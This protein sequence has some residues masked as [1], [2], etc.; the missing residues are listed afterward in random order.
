MKKHILLTVLS[1][2]LAVSC[3]HKP[4][5]AAQPSPSAAAN[6]LADQAVVESP[7][8]DAL[9]VTDVQA[10]REGDR[11]VS[12][13]F[14]APLAAAQDL[15]GLVES[16][17]FRVKCSIK[18][19]QLLVYPTQNADGNFRLTLHEGI[20]AEN[21][22]KT[23]QTFIYDLSFGQSL[24]QV[25]LV[26]DGVIA[27]TGE[28]AWFPFRAVGLNAVDIRII[29]VFP[30]NM[31]YFLQE[32][33]LDE[34]SSWTLNRVGRS[35]CR[36]KIDLRSRNAGDLS[37]WNSFKIDLSKFIDFKP[38]T[39][40]S[41]EIGFRK[42][43]TVSYASDAFQ[44]DASLSRRE[45]RQAAVNHDG[46]R[47]LLPIEEEE[48][49]P[50]YD[51]HDAYFTYCYNWRSSDNP[52][53]AAYYNP[54][55]RFPRR[56]VLC[57]DLGIIVKS[58]AVEGTHVFV[59]G[60]TSA[61]PEAG[62]DVEL[63][64][65][66]MQVVGQGKTDR[67]GVFSCSTARPVNTVFV[68]KGEQAGF[69]RLSNGSLIPSAAFD[70]SGRQVSKG[71]KGFLYA[72]RGVWRPGDSIFLNFILEDR[73]GLLPEGYP[74]HL[75][76][77]NAQGQ[78]VRRM[79]QKV[80][81]GTIYPF[82]LT[83]SPD[84]PTGNWLAVVKAGNLEFRKNLQVESVKPNRLKIHLT[85]PD[86][87]FSAGQTYQMALEAKWLT[88]ATA[89]HLPATVDVAYKP[90]TP[91]FAKFRRY[92][93]DAPTS[94]WYN[95]AE[96]AF[97]GKLSDNGTV[98]FPFAFQSESF[99]PGML[100]AE[101][102]TRVT[103]GEGGFSVNYQSQTI[104][105]YKHYAGIRL[106]WDQPQWN[107]L[108][109]DKNH[110]VAI[111]TVDEL[112][113]PAQVK[114]IEVKL[115]DLEYKWWY[116]GK[117]EHLGSYVGETYHKPV[118]S[119][120]T[121]TSTNGLGEVVLPKDSKR[122]GS[123]LLTVALPDGHTAGQ[124]VWFGGSWGSRPQGDAQVLT[125]LS[126]KGKYNVGEEVKVSFPVSG[127]SRALV[128]VES[129]RGI[130]SR[131]RIIP[132]AATCEY[133]FK[134]TP[135]MAPNVYVSV[136]LLQ[137]HAQTANDLPIRMFGVIPVE[138]ED[139]DTRLQPVLKAPADVRPEK[140]FNLTVAEAG[141]RP[142]DYTIAIVDEG[143][144]D[145]TRFATPDP[146]QHFYAREA[147]SIKTY[148]LYHQVLGAF[149]T[150][151]E[152][153][154]TIGGSDGRIDASKKR[155]DRFPPIVKVLG[156]FHLEKGK[157]GRH[158]VTLEPYTGSVRAMVVAAGDG[159]YGQTQQDISVTEP[160]MVQ[161]GLP[162]TLAPDERL[163]VAVN[164]FS[165]RDGLG[166]VRL[167]FETDGA[168]Q[169]AQS[170]DTVIEVTEAGEYTVPVW[171]KTL[172][173]NL[174]EGM[175]H[176]RVSA[177][178]GSLK[179]KGET[180]IAVRHRNATTVRTRF[181]TLAEG[182]SWSETL[183]AS[184]PEAKATLEVSSMPAMNLSHRLTY[185]LDYPMA[186]TEQTVSGAFPLLYLP[187]LVECSET[188]LA[189]MR[190]RV[191]QAIARLQR[192]QTPSHGFAVWPGGTKA[193]EWTSCY[194]T[195]FLSQASKS[196]YELP[197]YL[198][199]ESL[200]Y[201]KQQASVYRA[202]DDEEDNFVQAYRLWVLAEAGQAQMGCMNR[203]RAN[204]RLNNQGRYLLAHAYLL[205]GQSAAADAL[206]D[207]R[208]TK[209]DA[210]AEESFGTDLRD[211]SLIL[212]YLTASGATAEAS[213]LALDLAAELSS[214]DWL[215]TQSTAA[216]LVALQCFAVGTNAASSVECTLSCN[217]GRAC[218]IGGNLTLLRQ[219]IP[220]EHASASF[221]VTHT[222]QGT[223]FALLSQEERPVGP[224]SESLSQGLQLKCVYRDRKG[225][226]VQ[227]SRLRQ[228]TDFTAEI[229]VT[230]PTPLPVSHL[231]L[232]LAVPSG[233]ELLRTSADDPDESYDDRDIRD[234]RVCT[235]FRLGAGETRTF[236]LPLRSAWAGEFVLP[237]VT[238]EAMYDR[239][240]H[241]AQTGGMMV[242]VTE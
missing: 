176:L 121:R 58:D 130:L 40:Y 184:G 207:V 237:P 86:T 153:M 212:Q 85:S 147:L 73:E 137:P 90:F 149:G 92:R 143:L 65:Y 148:D 154:F 117:E 238:C 14:S 222:G 165:Q 185:L 126:D 36:R 89:A 163:R 114:N 69:L 188:E 88:G 186:C 198:L 146:W 82:H 129:S 3:Q 240:R 29:E 94:A 139:P 21:G 56:N 81:R 44:A 7:V 98:R 194:A 232:T 123:F 192:H 179:A 46:D 144:L 174:P 132:T 200:S 62:A 223:L 8:A 134:A 156:P 97:E 16:D 32:N 53:H 119:V 104:S 30:D 195:L 213:A 35:V 210:P 235:C 57:S 55:S 127:E 193:H 13:T 49:H 168:L 51:Y 112:G 71:V 59:N 172:S 197:A 72:D 159:R 228:G 78:M 47:F 206:V 74:L 96:T 20:A 173:G 99:V 110:V 227:A 231:M 241:Y 160:L 140:P 93:F 23:A 239:A 145:L 214:A 236:A 169:L 190:D 10:V 166:S 76:L 182:E 102:T 122:Y 45:Q 135:D 33:D 217:D 109:N 175:S 48:T 191:T 64:D 155:D 157:K 68:R 242:T 208:Q 60:L 106:A 218:R 221:K 204:G 211:K 37:R 225:N 128:T 38:G 138:V 125:L 151:L 15:R 229:S 224:D 5:P 167:H 18:S 226:E 215:S 17:A 162:K 171:L 22:L 115:Y 50:E 202:G 31:R 209:C 2:M 189:D 25:Q 111:A 234:D 103:E 120:K 39:L 34:A 75:D 101:F 77:Y 131:E 183:T 181:R 83:T 203:L 95:S 152:S 105:P 230:N 61:A 67:D 6:P 54:Y 11:Y 28:G 24:P 141:G 161:T 113:R 66:Q 70:V 80:G 26:G 9:T 1:A 170:P 42:G 19:D 220:F 52:Q 216:A 41:V 124:V 63:Y 158:E 180:A 84:D 133:R 118:F 12:V 233:W 150:R 142:M 100:R 116:Q 219:E 177:S 164:L 187:R 27:P 199:D 79:V 196:G 205:A 178:A 107:Q 43:Y 4:S 87:L 201:L 108:D 91:V 136:H